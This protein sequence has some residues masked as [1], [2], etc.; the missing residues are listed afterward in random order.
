MSRDDFGCHILVGGGVGG[1]RW[2][3]KGMVEGKGWRLSGLDI[4]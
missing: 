1:S 3:S 4:F 2:L